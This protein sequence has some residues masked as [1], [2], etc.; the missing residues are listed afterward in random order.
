MKLSEGREEK[1]HIEHF[2]EI[3]STNEEAKRR[4]SSGDTREQLLYADFQSAGKGRNGR[5]FYSPQDTGIYLSYLFPNPGNEEVRE[6]IFVTT[7]AAV[8]V[9]EAVREV[10]GADASIKWV[11]D[12][13]VA[14]RKVCGILAE[15][16][17]YRQ[18]PGIVVGIGINLSTKD[19]PDEIK[20]T[21]AGVGDY[22]KEELM[23]IKAEI[24]RRVGDG[25]HEFFTRFKDAAY[26][27]DLIGR[28][29]ANSMVIGK[30]VTFFKNADEKRGGV[31]KD[32]LEDGSLVVATD[33]GDVVL[34]SGEIHLSV[35]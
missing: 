25:F 22:S 20:D 26:R 9:C 24:L 28:Y 33:D 13:Y 1:Y 5:S 27:S 30:Q 23:R 3:D 2:A 11:N 6:L 19:F 14:G 8:F 10:T 31:A 4:F 34:N 12:V 15:V 17:Y 21:A 29:R 35:I 7:A 16:A 18:V 32:I